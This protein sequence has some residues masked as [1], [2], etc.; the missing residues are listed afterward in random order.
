MRAVAIAPLILALAGLAAADAT[1]DA[2]AS[3]EPAVRLQTLRT[4]AGGDRTELAPAVAVALEDRY[5][6]IRTA[7]AD[8]L[9]AWGAASHPA[10]LERLH[11]GSYLAALHGAQVAARQGAIAAPLADALLALL[12]DPQT[13]ADVQ[14]TALWALSRIGGAAPQALPILAQ[15]RSSWLLWQRY[16]QAIAAQGPAARP[17]V[18][19]LLEQRTVPFARDALPSVLE[20]EALEDL[21]W[22]L[23]AEE[24]VLGA[25]LPAATAIASLPVSVPD[26]TAIAEPHR[27]P[28]GR[29]GSPG[30][31]LPDRWWV[32]PGPV[33]PALLE[34]LGRDPFA[35]LR[36]WRELPAEGMVRRG[37][38]TDDAAADDESAVNPWTSV[39]FGVSGL[40]FKVVVDGLAGERCVVV[41]PLRL[42]ATTVL[43]FSWSA[44]T[45]RAWW[46]GQPIR[47]GERL[48]LAPGLHILVLEAPVKVGPPP[49]VERLVL[50]PRL[51][52]M[53]RL[54][55]LR[56]CP[57]MLVQSWE[58]QWMRD[59]PCPFPVARGA[60]AVQEPRREQTLDPAPPVPPP[61]YGAADFVPSP[62]HPVGFCADGNGW[63]EGAEP[64]AEWWTARPEVREVRQFRSGYT[65]RD[66]DFSTR[67]DWVLGEGTAKNLLWR[68]PVP[69]WGDCQPV[70][71]G[72]RVINIFDPDQVICYHADTG[73]VLWQDTLGVM[74]LRPD[75]ERAE[76]DRLQMCFELSRAYTLGLMNAN[77]TNGKHQALPDKNPNPDPEAIRGLLANLERWR[78]GP[79]AAEPER[80]AEALAY[81]RAALTAALAG[82]RSRMLRPAMGGRWDRQTSWLQDRLQRHLDSREH[83]KP[84]VPMLTY[85]SG[86]V[87]YAMASPVSD[88][89]VVGVCF[90]YGQVA[91]YDVVSGRRLWGALD[92]LPGT[93]DMYHATSPLLWREL[94][95]VRTRGIASEV[96]AATLQGRNDLFLRGNWKNTLRAYD[97]LTGEIRWQAELPEARRAGGSHGGHASPILAEAVA[98]DGRVVPV[99]LANGGEIVRP[100]DGRQLGAL[101]RSYSFYHARGG[102]VIGSAPHCCDWYRLRLVA[103]DRVVAEVLHRLPRC[104][105]DHGPTVLAGGWFSNRQVAVGSADTALLSLTGPRPFFRKGEDDPLSVAGTHLVWLNPVACNDH[106]RMR[107]DLSCL[108][109]GHVA[110]ASDAAMPVTLSRRNLIGGAIPVVDRLFA[111]YLQGMD[112][113]KNYGCYKGLPAWFGV[114]LGGVA[115][116]GRRL[117]ISTNVGMYCIGPAVAGTAQDDAGIV[118]ELRTAEDRGRVLPWLDHASAQYRYEAVRALRRLGAAPE[119][120][121]CRRLL[122]EDAYEEIRAEALLALEAAGARQ[123][124]W[125]SL[126]AALSED[127]HLDAYRLVFGG[128][129][130]DDPRTWRRQDALLTLRSLG[131]VAAR[132]LAEDLAACD[133]DVARAARFGAG[134]FL[135]QAHP[136]LVAAAIDQLQ[137]PPAPAAP[138]GPR[139]DLRT[140]EAAALL[141]CRH[142]PQDPGAIAALLAALPCLGGPP[143]PYVLLTL[144]RAQAPL[145]PQADAYIAL[146]RDGW[147]NEAAADLLMAQ[148]PAAACL[149]PHLR[150]LAADPELPWASRI[151]AVIAVIEGTQP[152]RWRRPPERLPANGAE[153]DPDAA[154]RSAPP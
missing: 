71:V 127:P 98:E 100:S 68:A 19:L 97:K 64:P 150:R 132:W 114:R 101:E 117:Y 106:W 2:L 119:L 72:K 153:P 62:A 96:D 146:L 143:L 44:P 92:V 3:P 61:A 40:R 46:S 116:H 149:L 137:R 28:G 145:G 103:P 13:A 134:A 105:G 17:L 136:A 142:A 128:G 5:A 48:R 26:G 63:Y 7:A 74:R 69:G 76:S 32:A 27:A 37:E 154:E 45:T 51:R 20:A 148:G 121:R 138:R 35:V 115:C 147:R 129:A 52:C 70:V 41:A 95:I 42:S 9:V 60:V 94:L 139:H 59:R 83:G 33:T 107:D 151:A 57:P 8:A 88:G 11:G 133:D 10:L 47:D 16:Y 24:P 89:Q 108:A 21:L 77:R 126:L 110:D 123:A 53:P 55:D 144:H 125:Q 87:G 111:E 141:L 120:D 15:P 36:S 131:E 79:L 85:W 50:N 118:Q 82:D 4:L 31:T 140:V 39:P 112:L 109:L 1:A 90:G 65:W 152:P 56:I 86:H 66:A 49:V 104:G 67:K 14:Q 54:T 58:S 29:A 84:M 91:V 6:E 34:E 38:D 25:A 81:D 130:E 78:L 22:R 135:A 75:E 113:S 80:W 73:A 43:Q 30:Y 124:P 122:A 102:L 93:G 99:I 23:Y 12:T 18:P